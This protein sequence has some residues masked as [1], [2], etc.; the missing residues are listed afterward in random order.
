M[1]YYSYQVDMFFI[2]GR[3]IELLKC[4]IYC[5]TKICSNIL[6]CRYKIYIIELFFKVEICYYEGQED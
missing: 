5:T 3:C 1:P 6:K 4:T 2:Y